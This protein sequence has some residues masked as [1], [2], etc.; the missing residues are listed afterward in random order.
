MTLKRNIFANFIGQTYSAAVAVLMVPMYLSYMGT[1]A[2]GLVGFFAMLQAWFQLLDV[3]LTPTMARETARY[4]GGAID[5]LTLQRLLRSLEC[6]FVSIAIV[7][8]LAISMSA[9]FISIHW[10]RVEQL[11]KSEVI[12]A[13][14]LMAMIIVLRWVSGLY[15]GVITGFER[16]VWLSGLNVIGA[17]ARFI[18]VIPYFIFVGSSPSEFFTYQFIVAALET[19]FLV[20]AAY[21]LMPKPGNQA[22]IKWHWEPLRKVLGFSLSIALTG[23]IW[24]FVTQT[25]KLILSKLLPLKE[26]AYFT[27]AVLVANGI[28]IVTSPVSG[29]L[30]PRL[31]KVWSEG[32][33][34]EFIHLYRVATQFVAVLAIPATLMLAFYS[35]SILWAWTGDLIVSKSTAPTLS[36]YAIG[37]GILSFAAFPYYL[38][39]AKGDLRLHILGSILFVAILIPTVIWATQN[40]GIEGA[41]YAWMASNALYFLFWVPVVHSKLIKK[42]HLLWLIYDIAPALVVS[43]SAI[44]IFHTMITLPSE[45]IWIWA[46]MVCGGMLLIALSLFASRELRQILINR[47][48]KEPV[49]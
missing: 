36:L 45:R 35:E 41:G 21:Q 9:E 43:L 27:L 49:A 3:G 8:G 16:I 39:Y 46:Y 28:S 23:S 44:F 30:L 31:T 2:Y 15:R 19:A 7:G 38:Q 18:L 48:R 32:N 42:T 24:V 1:E 47:L 13:V 14:I 34:S 40:H 17:T 20:F 5:A 22:S 25:D 11:S 6:V 33:E 37:Y 10:L 12:N 26:Y 4:Q 29:A